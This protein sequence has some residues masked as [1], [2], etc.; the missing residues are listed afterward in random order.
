[1]IAAL[2]LVLTVLTT[3]VCVL[4][5]LG[6]AAFRRKV[7]A[8]RVVAF[9]AVWYGV[10]AVLLLGASLLS[11]PKSMAIGERKCYFEWCI[12]LAK[13]DP[14]PAGYRLTFETSNEG[15]RAQRPDTPRLRLDIDGA[16]SEIDAPGLRDRVEGHGSRTFRV[17]VRVPTDAKEVRVTPCEGGFPSAIV[18]DDDN[19]PLHAKSFWR[20]R[21]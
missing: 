3:L 16:S 4:V 19:S 14:T 13:A 5:A 17:E 15:R 8:K 7:A 21:P 10:Y 12:S 1:M 18:V 9:L 20:V 6:L 11:S 2:Y